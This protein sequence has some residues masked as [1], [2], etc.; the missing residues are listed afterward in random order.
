MCALAL[1]EKKGERSF[2]SPWEAITLHH[3]GYDCIDIW[4]V[5][6]LLVDA[7]TDLVVV[8]VLLQEAL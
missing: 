8:D 1:D 5:S 2:L 7:S 4:I 3:C 6:W